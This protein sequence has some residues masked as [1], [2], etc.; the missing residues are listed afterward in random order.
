ME[1]VLDWNTWTKFHN[2]G[3]P[4]RHRTLK[5]MLNPRPRCPT[6]VMITH[7]LNHHTIRPPPIDGV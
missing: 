4:A 7:R 5:R 6:E 1:M 2:I 3:V